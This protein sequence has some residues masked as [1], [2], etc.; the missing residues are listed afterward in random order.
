MRDPFA[1]A[2]RRIIRRLGR[3]ITMVTGHNVRLELKGV[4]EK[5]EQDVISK[6]RRGGLNIKADVPTLTVLG[7]ECPTL[8]KA[9]RILVDGR[10]YYPVPSQSFDD[11]AGCIVIVLAEAIPEQ[12][13]EEAQHD[14]GKWR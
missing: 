6:G 2:S 13:N 1:K 3:P 4:F 8:D 11:G 10:E 7:S 9:L 14:G 12:S 5:P